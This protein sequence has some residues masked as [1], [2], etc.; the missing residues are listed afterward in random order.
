MAGYCVGVDLG[1]TGVGLTLAKTRT[2]PGYTVPLRLRICTTAHVFPGA[3][4][5]LKSLYVQVVVHRLL[6]SDA[7]G[8]LDYAATDRRISL[9][10]GL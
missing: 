10:N 1:Q 2:V 5:L 8:S 4:D 6:R 9:N 7:V 3:Q